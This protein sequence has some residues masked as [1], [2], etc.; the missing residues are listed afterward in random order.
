MRE[1]KFV[2]DQMFDASAGFT[3]LEHRMQAIANG[4]VGDL[5]HFT[6]GMAGDDE[7]G[8]FFAHLYEPAARAAVSKIAF[9]TYTMSETAI[10]LLETA[11]NFLAAENA[12]AARLMEK[13]PVDAARLRRQAIGECDPTGKEDQLPAVVD[14]A[15]WLERN[16]D[17]S[18]KG[19]ITK[20]YSA[21]TTW[22][23]AASL[24]AEVTLDA[25]SGVRI[26]LQRSEGLTFEAFEEYFARFIG[27]SPPDQKEVDPGNTMMVN[28]VAACRMLDAACNAYADHVDHVKRHFINWDINP[29]GPLQHLIR[30]VESDARIRKL[31]E[32]P[33]VL[34]GSQ[35]RV[36]IPESRRWSPAPGAPLPPLVR[37]P[38]V[39]SVPDLPAVPVPASMTRL[40]GAN[41]INAALNGLP[42]APPPWDG[43]HRPGVP[44]PVPPIFMPLT[45]HQKSDF[46]DWANGLHRHG[47]AGG[48]PASPAAL[49]QERV[50]GY[51]E[52]DLPLPNGK[53][54]QAD[55][56]RA[57]DGAIV[58]A[59]Y[60]KSPGTGCTP[61]TL[62]NLSTVD[63]D[64]STPWLTRPYEDD[65]SEL[66]RYHQAI[67]APGA[68]PRFVEVD[69]NGPESL[70][71]WQ[72]KLAEH[73]V[74]GY[75]RYVP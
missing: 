50:A 16:L 11:S 17:S 22:T 43:T 73:D 24:T 4:L 29:T 58:E 20:S 10:S 55:G 57:Q 6:E 62:E 15:N 34:D 46:Q 33:G 36:K 74:P 9:S 65:D 32:L 19:D 8:R 54:V 72:F 26:M 44:P 61:R 41:V 35:A 52:Y 70:P 37:V 40:A 1:L 2:I 14:K 18:P 75:A 69:T 51:P 59:K 5:D 45:P 47:Y 30:A 64:K 25:Q 68:H 21:A 27:W 39:P 3:D 7:A 71:Y 31:S 12:T 42:T 66:R 53:A 63:P 60:V 13:N 48:S 67:S 28:L 49:Y 23:R 38:G 56:L